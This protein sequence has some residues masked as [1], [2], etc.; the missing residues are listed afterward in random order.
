MVEKESSSPLKNLLGMYNPT[1]SADDPSMNVSLNSSR[2]SQLS[3]YLSVDPYL[4]SEPEFILPE[5][6]GR[7]RGRFEYAFGSIGGS[8]LAGAGVGTVNGLY[9][10]LL[11]TKGQIG[12]V[13]RT[14]LLNYVGKHGAA[15]ANSLGVVALMYSGFGVLLSWARG[16]DDEYNTIASATATGVLYKASAGL[17]RCGIAGGIGFGLATLYTL[18]AKGA[19]DRSIANYVGSTSRYPSPY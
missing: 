9:R 15:T 11:D 12:A 7:Q 10:G 13:R 1:Y 2:A 14:Q 16:T 17:K 8:V 5:G 19:N 4:A 3:P 18:W 6:S